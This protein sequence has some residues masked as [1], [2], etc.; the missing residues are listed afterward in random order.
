MTKIFLLLSLLIVS[1]YAKEGI[2]MKKLD[3]NNSALILI[4][5]QNEW[6]AKDSKLSFL[7]KDKEQFKKAKKNSKILLEYARKLNMNIIHVPLI[8]SDDYREFGKFKAQ[9]GLRSVIQE[10]KT[11]QGSSKDFYKDFIPRENEF[12]V[13]GRTGASGFAGS[14]LDSILRN[15]K[16]D[17]LYM[18]GFATNVCVESTLRE[19]HDKGYNSFIISDATSSFT[20]EEKD[21]FLKNIVHHFGK[22]LITQEFLNQKVVE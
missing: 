12:I 9:F 19:A 3:L 6:L 14:N 20:K 1:I 5:Y 2:K 22:S 15:N 18:I 11:W 13:K 16:I 21:F 8:I 17:N 10:V 7:M 4:E